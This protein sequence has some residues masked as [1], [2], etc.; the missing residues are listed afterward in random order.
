V[1]HGID[2][3][4]EQ[5]EVV[6]IIGPSGS[7]K[8]RCCAVLTCLNSRKG[9]HPGREITIDTGKSISQQKGLIRRLRQHVGFPE[10]QSFPHRTVLE[11]IIEGPVI[12]KG[13]R[14]RRVR[15]NCSLKLGWQVKRPA[16]RAACQGATAARGDSARWR[17]ALT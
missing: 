11:N 3:E 6:A 17:C 16:I 14:R 13:E 12:V 10:L 5:G 9:H 7:G 2:L 1:L 4:V 15:A 8:R